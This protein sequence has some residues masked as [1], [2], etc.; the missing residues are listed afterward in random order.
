MVDLKVPSNF[1]HDLKSPLRYVEFI[2][3]SDKT[4]LL[5]FLPNTTVLSVFLFTLV[6][7]LFLAKG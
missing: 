5:Q 3:L 1:T 7:F 6:M 2:N 4:Y